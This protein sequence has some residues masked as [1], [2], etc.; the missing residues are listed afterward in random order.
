MFGK[1]LLIIIG[2]ALTAIA[3]VVMRQQRIDT[4]HEI[5][6]TYDRL[7]DHE[8]TLWELKSRIAHATR[9]EEVERL[10]ME[11]D[12]QWATIPETNARPGP[13]APASSAAPT[14]LADA[15]DEPAETDE[16]APDVKDERIVRSGDLLFED[17][18]GVEDGVGG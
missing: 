9:P 1:L 8:R 7:R 10:M 3:L 14:A 17:E 18:P 13:D 12:E 5:A 15:D 16:P 2:I 11:L 4:H 6:E